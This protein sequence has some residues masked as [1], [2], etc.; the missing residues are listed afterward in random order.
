[1]TLSAI[2]AQR[3][4]LDA[5]LLYDEIAR[6][7]YAADPGSP[8]EAR[9]LRLMDRSFRRDVRRFVAAHPTR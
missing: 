6:R 4:W 9:L 8:D 2:R 5:T 1:M 7:F 3:L